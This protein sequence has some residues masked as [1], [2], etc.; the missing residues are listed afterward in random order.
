MSANVSIH[1]ITS[2]FLSALPPEDWETSGWV[3]FLSWVVNHPEC[4][5]SKGEAQALWRD[6]YATQLREHP[7]WTT[8]SH[9]DVFSRA[10]GKFRVLAG[11]RIGNT[12]LLTTT[13]GTTQIELEK[14]YYQKQFLL[15]MFAELGAVLDP[16]DD[17]SW[18][19]Y[20]SAFAKKYLRRVNEQGEM[21]KNE[22]QEVVEEILRKLLDEAETDTNLLVRNIAV[23]DDAYLYFR[24]ESLTK[25]LDR[26]RGLPYTGP[27]LQRVL[28]SCGFLSFRFSGKRI[29]CWRGKYADL[30]NL[31]FS[32][33]RKNTNDAPSDDRS[34]ASGNTIGTDRVDF[35]LESGGTRSNR[36]DHDTFEDTVKTL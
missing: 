18:K 19:Q 16:I 6:A 8:G 31:R 34:C 3:G 1:E 27:E 21:E 15:A 14:F 26:M 10:W 17:R 32:G 5:L 4:G 29:R 20:L 36:T 9:D 25:H 7:E 13:D 35:V 22:L 11:E 23:Q 24:T 33:L 30:E 2:R 12:V 28:R